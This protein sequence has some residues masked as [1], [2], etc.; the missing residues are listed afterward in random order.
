MGKFSW[1]ALLVLQLASCGDLPLVGNGGSNSK[2]STTQIRPDA[3]ALPDSG[4]VGGWDGGDP[5]FQ[6]NCGTFAAP[7]SQ[8]PV[9]LLV[10]LDRSG[11]MTSALADETQ[12]DSTTTTC[13]QRWVAMREAMSKVLTTAPASIHWGLK[14]FSTADAVDPAG[15]VPEGC[16]VTPG[17]EVPVAPDNTAALLSK[18]G[19]TIPNFNTPTRAAVAAAVAYF[20]TLNDGRTHNILLATDGQ[21]NCAELGPY[22]TTLDLPATLDTIAAANAQGIKVYVI[23]VGPSAGNLDSMAQKGGTGNFYPTLSPQALSSAL[24]TIAGL[25]ASCQFSLS[26]PPPNPAHIGVY[27]DKTLV[28]RDDPNGWSLTNNTQV[29]FGGTACAKIKSGTYQRVDVLFGCADNPPFIP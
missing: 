18:M 14:F 24:S 1:R 21:P 13:T 7:V 20:K 11:S 2:A 27:L 25:V 10:V 17:V 9:D 19:G 15:I 4:A 3:M 22:A 8:V 5:T 26:S 28:G 6:T 23:G 29:V 16:L 12:C